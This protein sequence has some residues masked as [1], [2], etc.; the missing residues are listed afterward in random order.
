MKRFYVVSTGA[1]LR[2]RLNGLAI[3]GEKSFGDVRFE[4]HGIAS[5]TSDRIGQRF[6][7]ALRSRVLVCGYG[8]LEGVL[9]TQKLIEACAENKRKG[10]E[11][12]DGPNGTTEAEFFQN[13][14]IT[15]ARRP[16]SR[17][18]AVGGERAVSEV[19]RRLY[20]FCISGGIGLR[21]V[22]DRLFRRWTGGLPGRRDVSCRRRKQILLRGTGGR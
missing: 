11:S 6:Y 5:G 1:E 18:A 21:W 13:S 22:G 16:A 8:I 15:L 14:R 10:C 12:G 20:L 2:R 7:S 4:G 17:V 3:F 19:G 9:L